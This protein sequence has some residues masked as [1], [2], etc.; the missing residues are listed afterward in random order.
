MSDSSA[1]IAGCATTGA[2]ALILLL[3]RITMGESPARVDERTSVV[4]EEILPVPAPPSALP[5]AQEMELLAELKQQQELTQLLEERMAQQTLQ[6]QDLQSQLQW[7]QQETEALAARLS[8]YEDFMNLLTTQQQQFAGVQRETDKTQ[9]SLLWVGAGLVMIVLI[10]GALVLVILV[11]LVAFQSRQRSTPSSQI[12]YTT[13]VPVP[14]NPYYTQQP[15]LPTPRRTRR[16]YPQ[17]FYD[18][19]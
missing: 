17:E 16:V 8:T 3:A 14:P 10:G 1:F 13:E 6:I 9:S 12:V 2:A 15:F 4:Q 7:Q 18:G 5:S 19:E 11:V